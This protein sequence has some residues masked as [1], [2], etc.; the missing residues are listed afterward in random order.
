MLQ[1]PVGLYWHESRVSKLEAVFPTVRNS[2]IVVAVYVLFHGVT[3]FLVA[4]VQKLFVSHITVFASLMYLPHGVRVLTTWLLGWKAIAPLFAGSFCAHFLFTSASDRAITDPVLFQ[5]LFVGAFSAYAGF[6]ILR[7][8]GRN[9]YA[10]ESRTL[11]WKWLLIVGAIASVFNSIGQSIVFYGL[12][13]P[14]EA[15]A[16]LA[17]FAV[18]DLVGLVTTMIA[19]LLIFRWIRLFSE[20]R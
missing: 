16:A 4:P 7:A 18:G 3:A 14:E 20:R 15:L 10:D 8:F 1:S 6:L 13:Y 9:I 5:S 17:I 12:I 2:L 11:S 19:L